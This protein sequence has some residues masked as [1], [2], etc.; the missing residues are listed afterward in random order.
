MG[1]QGGQQVGVAKI[2]DLNRASLWSG[3][4]ASWVDLTPTGSN[5]SIAY[6]VDGGQQVG[7]VNFGGGNDRAGLWSGTADSWVDLHSFLPPGFENSEA[8]AIWHDSTATYVVGLAR[9]TSGE[10][11]AIMWVGPV[12]TPGAVSVLAL[13]GL[14]TLRRRR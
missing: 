7:Y 14:V 6:G 13:S 3:T 10:E 9:F 12:P 11:R 8:H 1:V 2:N 5:W 4:A